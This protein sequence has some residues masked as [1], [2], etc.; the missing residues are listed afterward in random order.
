MDMVLR[1]KKLFLKL[2]V[3]KI[4]IINME[5]LHGKINKKYNN[6]IA[7][8]FGYSYRHQYFSYLFSFSIFRSSMFLK[9]LFSECFNLCVNDTPK[10]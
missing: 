6:L 4:G 8:A 3:P 1:S 10:K 2:V 7:E 5:K 9:T